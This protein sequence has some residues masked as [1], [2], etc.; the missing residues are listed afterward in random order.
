MKK[1]RA[2]GILL[3]ALFYGALAQSTDYK[4][5]SEFM[6]NE[7][8]APQSTE[9]IIKH[10][11][12]SSASDP[13]EELIRWTNADFPELRNEKG[14][15]NTDP[16][17]IQLCTD[18]AINYLFSIDQSNDKGKRYLDVIGKLNKNTT[19]I[20]FLTQDAFRVLDKEQMSDEFYRL[21]ALS[22]PD[23]RARGLSLGRTLAENDRDFFEVY[24]NA[25]KN[26]K[27]FQVR[28]TAFHI[29]G[30]I[31]RNY[32]R[33]IALL[34]LEQ[35]M[36]EKDPHVREIASILVKQ[37]TFLRGW[38]KED[39]RFLLTHLVQTNDVFVRN[40]IGITVAKLSVDEP[41]KVLEEKLDE[42][43]FEDLIER[44]DQQKE[45]TDPAMLVENWN[46]WW[47][48]LMPKYTVKSMV[49]ACGA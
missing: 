42:R 16:Y 47:K 21:M 31:R 2:I 38:N 1:I 46:E 3:F 39:I 19:I 33:E 9:I 44:I 8:R 32:S 18:S 48:S 10:L 17:S 43:G 41:L 25:A 13:L 4:A 14:T 26:D 27:S 30:M 22:D 45:K 7:R 5:M 12:Q 6:L 34:A 20:Y 24:V 37:G 11:E 35:L 28:N 40:C 15:W 23:E 29:L 36:I 49:I